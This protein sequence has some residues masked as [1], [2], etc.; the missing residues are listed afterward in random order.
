MLRVA[1]AILAEKTANR[2]FDAVIQTR[3]TGSLVNAAPP[4]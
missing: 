1:A 2:L 4:P 3:W